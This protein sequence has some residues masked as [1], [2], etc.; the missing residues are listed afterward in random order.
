MLAFAALL[1]LVWQLAPLDAASEALAPIAEWN[2][3]LTAA[4]L[5][6]QGIEVL[7]RGSALHHAGGFSCQIDLACTGLPILALIVAAIALYPTTRGLRVLTLALALP[8]FLTLN[9][10]RMVHLVRVGIEAPASFD[11]AHD[12]AWRVG[13]VLLLGVGWGAWRQLALRA[14][15][16]LQPKRS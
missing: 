6:L 16:V 12:V 7:R 4:I 10:A 5:K 8:L 13:L 15:G 3:R 14:G 1:T 2:A 9:L 11:F